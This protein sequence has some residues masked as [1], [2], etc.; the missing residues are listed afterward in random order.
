MHTGTRTHMHTGA[1]TRTH[2]LTETCMHTVTH[3]REQIK[4]LQG[5]RSSP[6]VCS[7]SS[8]AEGRTV[9]NQQLPLFTDLSSTSHPSW[10]KAEGTVYSLREGEDT[11]RV[12]VKWI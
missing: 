3:A 12:E 8:A 6:Y 5:A 10:E 11:T 1:C 2:T 9:Q 4:S 7:Y